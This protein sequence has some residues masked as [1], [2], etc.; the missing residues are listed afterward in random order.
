M[1][2][3]VTMCG[4]LSAMPPRRKPS[5]CSTQSGGCLQLCS[6]SGQLDCHCRH[7]LC[8]LLCSPVAAGMHCHSGCACLLLHNA[9]RHRN[10]CLRAS[11]LT[12]THA[13]NCQHLPSCIRVFISCRSPTSASKHD[14]TG[15]S[16]ICKVALAQRL[17]RASRFNVCETTPH[18]PFQLAPP[19]AP[20]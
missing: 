17:L 16:A 5:R 18:L 2:P 12:T 1:L 19:A 9:I 11:A 7:A 6:T 4:G 20:T 15:V 14:R 8:A 13:L 10:H 3:S